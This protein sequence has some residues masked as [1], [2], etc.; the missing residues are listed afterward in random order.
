MDP[1][2]R[3]F[4]R[5]ADY[6]RRFSL[7]AQD[8]AHVALDCLLATGNGVAVMNVMRALSPDV[9]KT[10]EREVRFKGEMRRLPSDLPPF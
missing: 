8:E 1:K 3:V 4:Y 7:D 6:T 10:F 9:A 2:K 5:E